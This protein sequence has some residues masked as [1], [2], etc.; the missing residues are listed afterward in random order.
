V[1]RAQDVANE[2]NRLI[3]NQVWSAGQRL[4]PERRLCEQ[5]G[6]ARLT[7]RRALDLVAQSERIIRHEGR[8]CY[9]RSDLG[10]AAAALSCGAAFL[11]D[12]SRASPADLMELRL[13]VEPAAA[14]L[15]AIRA[16]S[17]DL[18]KIERACNRITEVTSFP[19]REQAD[20]DFHL[21]LF[22]AARNPLLTALCRSI[23]EVRDGEAWIRK[24]SE[25]LT[26]ERCESYDRQHA[27]IVAALLGRDVEATTVAVREHLGTLRKDLWGPGLI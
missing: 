17:E 5:F 21:A 23:N 14:S 8:G 16:T 13:I 6:S 26:P 10:E 12:L 2:I 19:G 24:K 18:I 4:P 22:E 20:A 1:P 3:D 27:A 11:K 15:A 9:V 25:I 7:L